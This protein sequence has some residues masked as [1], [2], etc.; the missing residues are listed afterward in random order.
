MKKEKS[1]IQLIEKAAGSC[2][3]LYCGLNADEVSKLPS[4]VKAVWKAGRDLCAK[5]ITA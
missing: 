5:G 2:I 3:K 4:E 1:D